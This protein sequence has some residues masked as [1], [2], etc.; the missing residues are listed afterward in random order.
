MG[1]AL[2]ALLDQLG[3]EVRDPAPSRDRGI[4]AAHALVHQSWSKFLS[5]FGVGTSHALVGYDRLRAA[6]PEPD[7][8]TLVLLTDHEL[9]LRDFAELAQTAGVDPLGPVRD[10]IERMR[11][12]G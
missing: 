1:S 2:A 11:P 3:V 6:S 4:E 10:V 7:H 5:V 8:P 12:I 9:A